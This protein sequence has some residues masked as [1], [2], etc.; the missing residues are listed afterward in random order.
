MVD[1]STPATVTLEGVSELS[2][3]TIESN[4]RAV[5]LFKR[6][7]ESNDAFAGAYRGLAHAYLQR[8]EDLGLGTSWLEPA[9]EAANR[10]IQLDP[11]DGDAYHVLGRVYRI[12]GWLREELQ[13]W[14][15]RLRVAPDDPVANSRVGWVL[16]FTGRADESLPWLRTAA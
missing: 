7:V 13:V 6:V 3:E 4:E 8:T 12:K 5:A 14:Q 15:Q 2:H 1:P 11:S 10:A 16:W 9:A